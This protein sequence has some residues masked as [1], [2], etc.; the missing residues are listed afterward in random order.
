MVLIP[1]LSL[2]A[3]KKTTKYHQFDDHSPPPPSPDT[4]KSK[5]VALFD[6]R[7][8]FH[9]W[10]FITPGAFL[11]EEDYC[12]VALC[13]RGS[14]CIPCMLCMEPQASKGRGCVFHTNQRT[15][16]LRPWEY[17]IDILR[18]MTA[19]AQTAPPTNSLFL[20]CNVMKVVNGQIPSTKR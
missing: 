16:Q 6:W 8:V 18:F 9:V 12:L 20:E 14:L 10:S 4:P 7:L 3:P 19:F 1:E 2:G 13:V 5:N 15:C 17:G 11:V